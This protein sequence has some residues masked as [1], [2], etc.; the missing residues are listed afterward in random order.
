MQGRIQ[1]AMA[2]LISLAGILGPTLYTGAF[3]LFIGDKAPIELPGMP[4]FIASL[5]LALALLLAL[6]RRNTQGVTA[7]AAP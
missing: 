4:W 5:L 1:G 2:S 3:A 7:P 6:R